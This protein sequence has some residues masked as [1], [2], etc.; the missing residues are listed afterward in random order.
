MFLRQTSKKYIAK[1]T[2]KHMMISYRSSHVVHFAVDMVIS[3]STPL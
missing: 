2:A 3:V 1:H